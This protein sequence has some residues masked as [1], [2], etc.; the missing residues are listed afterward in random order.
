MALPADPA[1]HLQRIVL[2][3]PVLRL[4]AARS[5]TRIG[6]HSGASLTAATRA[7]PRAARARGAEKAADLLARQAAELPIVCPMAVAPV[8]R[9]ERDMRPAPV[10]R[11]V[12][13][14]GYPGGS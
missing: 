7:D 10:L 12:V 4:V 6:S 5:L 2:K 13:T 11:L 9:I 8:E 3:A 14:A 1:G